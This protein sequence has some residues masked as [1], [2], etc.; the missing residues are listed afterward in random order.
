MALAG[1]YMLLRKGRGRCSAPAIPFSADGVAI[2]TA[3]VPGDGDK[4]LL[5]VYSPSAISAGESLPVVIYL[6]GGGWILGSARGYDHVAVAICRAA[7]VLVLSV[8]YRLAPE[9][10]FP[11]SLD[12]CARSIE[13]ARKNVHRHCGDPGRIYLAGDSAGGNLA[14]SSAFL[15]SPGKGDIRGVILYYP[16][17]NLARSESPSMRRFGKGYGLDADFFEK[18]IRL[19][20]PDSLSRNRPEVSPLNADPR[21]MPPALVV[22]A[23]CDILRDDA[24]MFADRLAAGGNRVRYLCVPGVTHAFLESTCCT[25][26][27]QRTIR[28]T[29][30]FIHRTSR[31]V[32]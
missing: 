28:E 5:R 20:V 29:A 26:E 27:F 16:A 3:A 4:L 12:D 14:A 8:D 18:A 9:H 30:E 23:Q 11:A 13:W 10:P 15:Q 19:Y 6:H 25:V 2:Q 24:K 7:R 31:P 17:L 22:A 32:R 1:D 21:L